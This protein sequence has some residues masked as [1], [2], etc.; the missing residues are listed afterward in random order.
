MFFVGIVT[1][2]PLPELPGPGVAG[3]GEVLVK[4]L[5]PKL[6]S[7][8]GKGSACRTKG[9]V[10]FDPIIK[11]IVIQN[12]VPGVF[13]RD[14]V[15]N[16]SVMG[17]GLNNASTEYSPSNWRSFSRP[18]CGLHLDDRAMHEGVSTGPEVSRAGCFR[19]SFYAALLFTPVPDF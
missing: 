6:P 16:L 12:G 1:H 2:T 5:K 15:K 4:E 19:S 17:L 3:G 14:G 11:K 9:W 10:K 18:K 13:P 7:L 8:E